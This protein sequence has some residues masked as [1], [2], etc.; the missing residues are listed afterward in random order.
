[1][2]L[3][4][5]ADYIEGEIT[6]IKGEILQ[7]LVGLRDMVTRIETPV[8]EQEIQVIQRVVEIRHDG[9]AVTNEALRAV[10]E[11]AAEEPE[12]TKQHPVAELEAE[13]PV[14]ELEAEQPV[15][16]VEAE[17]PV[18]EVEQEEQPVAEVE[19]EEQPEEPVDEEPAPTLEAVD[20][21]EMQPLPDWFQQ[22]DTVMP[23]MGSDPNQQGASQF[24][25]TG[26]Y[27]LI[28]QDTGQ[29]AA[30]VRAL[31]IHSV[32]NIIRWVGGIRPR[33]GLT[34]LWTLLEIYQTTGHMPESIED[35]ILE[36]AKLDPL[37]G[38]TD[39]PGFTLEEYIDSIL[40]LHA[41]VSGLEYRQGR[42][43]LQ[44]AQA[45]SSSN[46]SARMSDRSPDSE[47]LGLEL[48]QVHGQQTPAGVSGNRRYPDGVVRGYGE[49][50][51][52]DANLVSNLMRWA[53]TVR[54]KIGQGQWE[55][56]LRVYKLTGNLP[57]AVEGMLLKAAQLET[58]PSETD[59]TGF[60]LQDFID[61]LLKLHG[62]VHSTEYQ[63]GQRNT[64]FT[65]PPAVVKDIYG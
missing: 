43:G 48:G 32:A 23:D 60:T 7:T 50:D 63:P 20:D 13:H 5:R 49:F 57:P 35:L 18:A 37:P 59:G 34:Q 29:L 21:N 62:I 39:V 25:E 55:T 40:Q 24:P 54:P 46:G 3:E 42:Y 65:P 4:E 27:Q 52:L 44:P 31:D 41:I 11:Q 17:Q 38:T 6:L 9:G 28:L 12:D 56:L 16:E 64:E 58:L 33:I 1:M 22:L 30:E 14:A 8:P 45:P 26:G 2:E 36:A 19:Q 10:E 53:G 15:A 47:H 61:S 51:R